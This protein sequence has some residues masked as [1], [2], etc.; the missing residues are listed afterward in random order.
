M[1]RKFAGTLPAELHAQTRIQ[2]E[3]RGT[4]ANR[5]LKKSENFAVVCV[6][7]PLGLPSPVSIE[8]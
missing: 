6:W 4:A 7:V 1:S 5:V 2:E 3:R 8:S